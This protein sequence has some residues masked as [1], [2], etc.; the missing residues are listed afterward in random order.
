M[1]IHHA[2]IKKA[3]KMG[4]T[5][6]ESDTGLV[7]AFWPKRSLGVEFSSA[8]DAIKQ[9]AA[10][11]E[12]W[13]DDEFRVQAV[14]EQARMIDVIRVEDGALLKGCPTAPVSALEFLRVNPEWIDGSIVEVFSDVDAPDEIERIDGVAIDGKVAYSEGTPAGDCPYTSETEDDEEYAD[15]ER[16][17]E[18]WDSAADEAESEE[19]KT[20]GSV[21]NEKYRAI[22]AERGHPTHCGDWLAN[23]L[24]EQCLNKGGTNLELFED[25]CGLNGVDLSK[26]N[27]TSRGWQGRFRM[28]GRNLL[29]KR[30]YLAD[31][32]LKLPGGVTLKAPGEWMTEQKYKMPKQ[33]A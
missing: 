32:V 31:G 1:G 13:T 14:P 28:T 17:N 20:T 22:Y 30:V 11:Q 12:I 16:W 2:Q 21:V 18:E 27:R 19:G 33:A 25:I 4:I 7:G 23:T 9:M 6:T 15:F 26:Y 5:L 29:A 24:N 8:A 3:E 10:V